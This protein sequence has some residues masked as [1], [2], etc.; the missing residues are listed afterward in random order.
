MLGVSSSILGTSNR[1]R[2]R[3]F[4][5][6][7]IFPIGKIG[8]NLKMPCSFPRIVGYPDWE[9]SDNDENQ[10]TRHAAQAST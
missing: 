3:V 2:S 10:P 7:P 6:M 4:L 5:K 8:Q 1:W 9:N